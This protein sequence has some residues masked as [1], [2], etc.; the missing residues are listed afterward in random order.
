M[1]FVCMCNGLLHVMT[2]WAS[3]GDLALIRTQT[4]E[5]LAFI[6]GWRLFAVILITENYR[7]QLT[8]TD[9]SLTTTTYTQQTRNSEAPT[10]YR[11]VLFTDKYRQQNGQILTDH[12][13][14]NTDKYNLPATDQKVASV[15][16]T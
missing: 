3:I 12:N 11:Q 1:F 13:R 6:R 15:Q 2:V 10:I 8:T 5:L 16:R 4:S 14:Q 9:N 7:Q